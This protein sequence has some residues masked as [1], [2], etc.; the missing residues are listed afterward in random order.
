MNY[1][2][3]ELGSVR[4]WLEGGLT[5]FINYLP[6]MLGAMLIVF[7]GWLVARILRGTMKRLFRWANHG[8]DRLFKRGDMASA[9]LSETAAHILGT[10]VFWL[11]IFV[12]IAI[13][14]RVAGL[15]TIYMWLDQ[16]VTYLPNLIVGAIIIVVGYIIS[17]V[18]GE[19]V[20]MAA[21]TA[22]SGQSNILGRLAQ[23]AVMV[24][25]LIIGLDQLGVDVTFLVALFAVATGAIFIGFSLAFGL[26]ARD[27]VTD[28]VSARDI[29]RT[30]KP[31]LSVRIGDHE[32]EV[33]EV[34]P[35]RLVLDTDEG[36]VLIAGRTAAT[37]AITILSSDDR[38]MPEDD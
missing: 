16:I 4:N 15:T 11:V 33:L 13:A 10:L 37:H 23:V 25:A 27:F 24:A 32:G 8:L 21:R 20:T 2:S 12:A 17:E 6:S 5:A 9:R 31:G 19:Q 14:S 7:L 28:L 30:I 22:R 38:E 35:T 29:S 1:L 18:V 26:G 3:N 34:T 36:R